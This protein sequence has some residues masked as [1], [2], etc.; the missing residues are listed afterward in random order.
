[1]DVFKLPVEGA[2]ITEIEFIGDSLGVVIK[3]G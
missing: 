1:M 2:V 3:K